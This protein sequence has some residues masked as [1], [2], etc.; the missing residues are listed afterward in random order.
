MRRSLSFTMLAIGM[1]MFSFVV[2]G[3]RTCG[4]HEVM[5]QQMNENPRFAQKLQLI[6]THTKQVQ[7]SPMLKAAGTIT[8]PV[9]VIVVYANSNQNIS[10]AQIQSQLDVL[11]LDFR[12]LNSDW[13]STPTEFYNLVADVEIEFTLQDVERHS[14]SRSSWGTNDAVKSAY[15]PY[16]P[17]T[18][19]NMWVCNI[20]GGILGYAQFPGGN[21]S[22]DGVV[23][24]SQ[25][26]GSSDY[27]DGS[28]YL[29]AP[30]DKGRTTT[31]EIG[32]WL[33]LRH[34]WGDGGCGAS[35]YVNDTPDSEGANYGC[36]T[37]PDASC[38]SND[39]FMNYMDYVDDACMYMFSEGQKTRARAIFEPGG[40]RES[41]VNGGT[42][43]CDI[44]A[45]DGNVVLNLT[46]D[47][48]PSE[49][50]WTLT[51]EGGV[52]VAQG[53]GYNT[54]GQTI[55]ENWN[56]AEGK[57][58]FTIYD[59]YGDGI[60]C[61]YG[62]GSYSLVDGCSTTLQSGGNFG[63][64]EAITFCVPGGGTTN[65]PPV[66][67]AN[68]PY[69]ADEGVSISFSSAGSNDTDGIIASY[70]WDF[71]DGQTSTQQNPSHTYAS[72]G[73][74]NVTLTV[75]D[76]DG[77]SD[78]DATTA[79]ITSTGGGGTDELSYDDFESGWGAW[80]DGGSD[81]RR[82]TGGTYA[83]SGNAAINIQDN[84]GAS[85]SFY[86]TNYYDVHT[87]GYT[88][89]SVEFIFYPR[90][91]ENGEDF[92]V[93]YYD[94]SGWRT[95][96]SYARGTDFNNNTFYSATV[97]ILEA[98]YTFPTNMKIRFLCDASGNADD[99]YV[100]DVRVTAS[101]GTARSIGTKSLTP[102]RA[103]RTVDVE[104]L[105]EEL[106]VYPNPTLDEL[107][108]SVAIED[109]AVAQIY[110]YNGALIRTIKLEEELTTINISELAAGIYIIKVDSGDEVMIKRIIKQ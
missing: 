17:N 97:N 31:H 33:N 54:K 3:Q 65:T 107:N 84:S 56:L 91:M 9:H 77:A 29:S 61:A 20:G 66:A 85:S 90:S 106:N 96:A 108:I 67:N 86:H 2:Y 21:A 11:N 109:N 68:G 88:Q 50:S 82:Y 46:L 63:S 64:S 42:V 57:Y 10:N 60:C 1:L 13:P 40:P 38:G 25:Y 51:E 70:L 26:F 92:W 8:I 47:D 30:F 34:I 79:N 71:G 75:T 35:D 76:N 39:M 87:N 55:T 15:P 53:S 7:Y 94:G 5:L 45:C 69:S 23:I 103:L 101:S 105:T 44:D 104:E 18:H 37:H 14:D 62:N 110:N 24:G 59:S 80:S 102:L 12:K 43:T 95:V 32:H 78:S 27:D 52:T 48:Y 93:Q 99:V 28:F 74:Y 81:C 16:S 98:N 58:T 49:T 73:T 72:S 4:S 100:D 36:P 41:F 19:L 89:I 22:T 6:E 83:Y